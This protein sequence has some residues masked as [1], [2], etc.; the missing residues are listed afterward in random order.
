MIRNQKFLLKQNND[1]SQLE[2]I[3]GERG[4]CGNHL[5]RKSWIRSLADII[6]VVCLSF[7]IVLPANALNKEQPPIANMGQMSFAFWQSGSAT[8]SVQYLIIAGGGGG[9]SSYGGG[10]GGGGLIQGSMPI[11][12]NTN[13][14]IT[15]GLGGFGSVYPNPSSNGGNTLAFGFTAYGGGYGGDPSYSGHNI[16]GSGGSGG[17][18]GSN[19][20]GGSGTSGQGNAGGLGS[21]SQGRWRWRWW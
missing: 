16:G 9:G 2:K 21:N 17:G 5:V 13:Y 10:G 3:N 11:V 18:G 7:Y 1:A 6:I 14:S 4:L 8:P 15:V 20:S 12:T 19:A